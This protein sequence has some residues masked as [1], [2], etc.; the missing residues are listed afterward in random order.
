MD[1]KISTL[2]TFHCRLFIVYIAAHWPSN[3]FLRKLLILDSYTDI[4][5]IER[6][7]NQ[8]II[9]LP[10]NVDTEGLQ[11]FID[12]LSYKETTAN[13]VAKQSDVDQLAK[14]SKK[15]WWDKNRSRFIK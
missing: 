13:S 11:K 4:M 14:D 8:I 9:R 10:A 7:N 12:Y 3:L 15:G 1:Q 5:E 2:S 6:T